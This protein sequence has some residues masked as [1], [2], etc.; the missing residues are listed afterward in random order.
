MACTAFSPELTAR[1]HGRYIYDHLP[2]GLFRTAGDDGSAVAW[3]IAPEPFAL[4]PQTFERIAA[5]GDDLLAF[6][7]VL[8]G[9]YT[10]SA[11]GTVPGFIAEYLDRGK[12]ENIIK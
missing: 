4:S 10:R 9:L 11:R 2:P 8:N 3:R 1:D 5:L 12:P 7:R 6:Y